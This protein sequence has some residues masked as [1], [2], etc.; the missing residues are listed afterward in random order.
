MIIFTRGDWMLNEIR[1]AYLDAKL[2]I[3]L[4]LFNPLDAQRSYFLDHINEL[5]VAAVQ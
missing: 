3:D 4:L 2:N 5:R 1:K